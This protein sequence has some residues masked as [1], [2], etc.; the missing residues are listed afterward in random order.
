MHHKVLVVDATYAL[1]GGVNIADRY[2]DVE[3][4]PAWLDFALEIKGEVALQLCILC[5]KTWKGFPVKMDVSNCKNS[6]QHLQIPSD[7]CC[8]M[9]VRRND[10]VRRKNEISNSY[11]EMLRHSKSQITI[12]C[13]Y[14][15]PGKKMRKQ[16]RLATKRGVHI[17]VI[18]AGVSD[19]KVA[20]YA[21][22]WLY[23][24][25]L[26]NKVELYEYQKT[27]IA[28]KTGRM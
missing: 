25:L 23:D 10:W 3:N 8:D 21:E 27:V 14:F 9:R 20:K 16:L 11:I 24:W 6:F 4:I 28:W 18:A 5:M 7:E 17:R 1:V 15:L 19:I 12:L 22:R 2:N 26:R 13:S